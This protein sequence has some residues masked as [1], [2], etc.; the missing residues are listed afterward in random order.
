MKN[1]QTASIKN[2]IS[3]FSAL[4]NEK[5]LAMF[6]RDVATIR[7]IKEMAA[8]WQAVRLLEKKKTYREISRETGLSTATIIR[9]AQWFR[10]GAGGYRLALKRIAK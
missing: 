1:W 9:V 6:L 8:R 7:E 10:S 2:L 4:K 5:E 3:T